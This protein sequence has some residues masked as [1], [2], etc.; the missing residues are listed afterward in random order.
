MGYYQGKYKVKHPEK[1]RGNVGDVVY[2]SS[3]EKS[4]FQWADSHPD[5][6]QWSSEEVVVPYLFEVDKRYHRYFIDMF[7][8]FKDRT[9]LVEIKPKKETS[10][11][12]K[13]GKN[14]R[15]YV[16][17]AFTYVKNKNKWNAAHKYAT[18]RGWHFEV[19][20]EEKLK[21]MGILKTLGKKQFK[22]LKKLE[23]YR[24][25]KAAK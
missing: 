2:R 19:W 23:P 3:W 1:Y 15:Q 9:V 21:A 22:P 8:K 20:T 24:K 4:C 17:E 18:D 25:K 13:Q 16:S 11:P 5:V 7:I 12:V 14:K 10:V 6:L